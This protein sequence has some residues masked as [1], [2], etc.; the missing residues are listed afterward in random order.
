MIPAAVASIETSLPQLSGRLVWSYRIVWCTL[1]IGA[2]LAS[3]LFFFQPAPQPAVLGLR[4]VKS[5]V[6]VCVATI[7]LYRRQR[8]PVAALLALAFLAWTITRSF[9]FGTNAQMAQLLDRL[10][11]LLFA[12]ALLLFPDAQWGPGWT[13][14]VATIS[15]GAFLIGVGEA[16]HLLQT[17]LFLPI[18]IPCVLAGIGSLVVRFRRTANYALKQQLKWVALGLSAGVG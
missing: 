8:D 11:F 4:L 10:R 1:A 12:L 5:A 14:G 2:L 18:T 7:L 16:L 13:R 3:G 17:H 9:D 15:A 6:L